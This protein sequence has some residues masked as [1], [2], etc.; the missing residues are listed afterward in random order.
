[1]L[2][3]KYIIFI[4]VF[5]SVWQ[6]LPVGAN[7]ALKCSRLFRTASGE[8][9]INSCNSCR[10][11]KLQ[12]KR[13]GAAAPITRTYTVPPKTTTNLSFRGPGRSRVLSD[14]SCHPGV[15]GD[16]EIGSNPLSTTVGKRCILMQRVDKAG[17]TGLALANTCKE[18]RIVVVDRVD[19]SGSRRSQ[20]I[21]ISGN[22]VIPLPANGAAQAGIMSEKSCK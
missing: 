4:F 1:M 22:S 18:C 16:N 10:I 13:P 3:K 21:A 7:A 9:L 14:R 2:N 15:V 20:N 6:W 12:R 11:V 8:Q 17:V 19:L 5:F